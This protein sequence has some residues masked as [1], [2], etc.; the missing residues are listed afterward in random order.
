MAG[1]SREYIPS[2][3]KDALP[4]GISRI[5]TIVVQEKEFRSLHNHS[6]TKSVERVLEGAHLNFCTLEVIK[7]STV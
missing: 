1:D 6:S 3:V 5:K 7:D 2:L 4:F